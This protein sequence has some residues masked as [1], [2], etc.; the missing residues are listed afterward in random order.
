MLQLYGRALGL[1]GLDGI[2]LRQQQHAYNRG[3]LCIEHL[4]LDRQLSWFLARAGP[5]HRSRPDE[6][7]LPLVDALRTR[8]LA[9][10]PDLV[11][12]P[13]R[14]RSSASLWAGPVTAS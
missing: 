6:D 3:R 8:L 14:L 5:H 1:I 12:A 4:V 11:E 9:P 10:A 7:W 2:F 13:E